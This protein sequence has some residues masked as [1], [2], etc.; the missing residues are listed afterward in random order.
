MK[1]CGCGQSRG[2]T[3]DEIEKICRVLK[4][5]HHKLFF[6]IAW[7]TGARWGE[8]CQLKVQNLYAEDWT[9]LELITF[10]RKSR[11]GKWDSLQQPIGDLLRE[12][13]IRYVPKKRGLLY[14]GW[15]FPSPRR[16]G[17]HLTRDAMDDVLQ[18]AIDKLG[19]RHRGYSTHGFRVGRITQLAE[20]GEPS[21][22]IQIYIGHRSLQSTERYMER[23]RIQQRLIHI[24]NA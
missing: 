22:L 18:R 14:P 1:N 13:L 20:A 8:L 2:F 7:F 4:S 12:H 15:M 6:R 11:K 23:D 21:R 9:P 5:D 24:A 19:W 10:E 17:R 3:L 16:H